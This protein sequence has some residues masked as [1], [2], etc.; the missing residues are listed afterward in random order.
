MY[1]NYIQ[2]ALCFLNESS[3]IRFNHIMR[4]VEIYPNISKLE[5]F[6][7]FSKLP[8]EIGCLIIILP[9][10]AGWISPRWGTCG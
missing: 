1:L 8:S 2:C 5:Q 4:V 9:C 6:T 10:S 7:L 3:E